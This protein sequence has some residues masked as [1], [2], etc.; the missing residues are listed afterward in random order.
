MC[1]AKPVLNAKNLGL[2]EEEVRLCRLYIKKQK[3]ALMAILESQA[4]TKRTGSPENFY[5]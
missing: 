5:K 1:D 4:E 2:S 3:M